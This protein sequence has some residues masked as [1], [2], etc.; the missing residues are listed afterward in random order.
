MLPPRHVLLATDLSD[1]SDRA[2]RAA[3][4]LAINVG[5]D[6]VVV[7]AREPAPYPYAVPEGQSGPEM[8]E[9]LLQEVAAGLKTERREAEAILR[10]GEPWKEIVSVAKERRVDLIVIGTH[11]RR[12]LAR[13]VLGSVAEKVVRHSPV[14]VLVVPPWR[15]DDRRDAGRQLADALSAF[16][17]TRPMVLALSGDAL[18]VAYEVAAGLLVPL[19]FWVAQLIEYD[20]NPVG[21]VCEDGTSV[22]A[23]GIVDQLGMRALDLQVAIAKGRNLAREQ[24]SRLRGARWMSDPTGRTIIVVTDEVASEWQVAAAAKALRAM[25]AG[26]I[27]LASPVGCTRAV[28]YLAKCVDSITC[29][30]EVEDPHEGLALYRDARGPTE[31]EAI[32]LLVSR[33]GA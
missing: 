19:D 31:A 21:S 4:Q 15:Y 14:P 29:L 7:Y 13:T 9:H 8:G 12:G 25:G 16:Q 23:E 18:P 2:T 1:G 6:L 5:A 33:I 17:G 30:E 22:V 20:G 3:R 28:Q 24:S 27:V 10:V 32:D 26:R 11:G